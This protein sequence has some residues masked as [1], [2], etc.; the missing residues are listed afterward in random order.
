LAKFQRH[1]FLCTNAREPGSA[2]PS[3]AHRGSPDLHRLF[4]EKIK[5]AGLKATVRANTAGC[6]DQCEHGPTV[7]IYP[8][9]VWYGFVA[10][11]DVDEIVSKHLVEGTPVARLQLDEDCLNTATCPHRKNL[12]KDQPPASR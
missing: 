9:A 1:V 7:V 2:R 4:K 3:C 5:D 10:P 12:V 11:E 6:L 8:E